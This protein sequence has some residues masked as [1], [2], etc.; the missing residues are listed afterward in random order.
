M[1]GHQIG[2]IHN[3][4][5]RKKFS[6]D[7]EWSGILDFGSIPRS[8][9][10]HLPLFTREQFLSEGLGL[11]LKPILSVNSQDVSKALHKVQRQGLPLLG[12]T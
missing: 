3:A 12:L 6:V 7:S 5:P 10:L 2:Y 11:Y 8:Y 4:R 9:L 1:N